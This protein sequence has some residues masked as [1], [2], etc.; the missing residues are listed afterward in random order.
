M[1]MYQIGTGKLIL[2]RDIK[3]CLQKDKQKKKKHLYSKHIS[4]IFKSRALRG[5]HPFYTFEYQD[6]KQSSFDLESIKKL[7]S[8]TVGDL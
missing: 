6:I 3:I 7:E 8:D 1:G 4:F 2:G 5:S